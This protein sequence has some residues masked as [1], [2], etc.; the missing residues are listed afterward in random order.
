MPT[1]RRLLLTT[2]AL[3][4]LAAPCSLAVDDGRYTGT[5]DA[6]TNKV[7]LKVKDDKVVK[8]SAKVNASCGSDDLLIT[9]AYPPTG[10][11]GAKAKIRNKA[12]KATFK[13]DPSLTPDED[14]RTI[15]GRFTGSKV[16][17]AIEVSGL[18]SYEGAY[19]A[20]R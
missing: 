11:R 17:G 19:S 16:A 15:T 5:E 1:A 14:R 18:C 12:F 13:S 7:S 9:V 6:G 3:A 8:F 4:L 2:T 10:Q 20:R